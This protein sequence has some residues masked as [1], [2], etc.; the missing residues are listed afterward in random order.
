M[1][2]PLPNGDDFKV[3]WSL[4]RPVRAAKLVTVHLLGDEDFSDKG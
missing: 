4:L 1:R 2:V 3:V